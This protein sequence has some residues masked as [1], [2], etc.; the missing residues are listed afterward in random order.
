MLKQISDERAE[1][2]VAQTV[3]TLS[4]EGLICTEEN[5]SAMRRVARGETTAD[6]EI[7]KIIK[8]FNMRRK[9]KNV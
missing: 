2:I 7:D 1:E 4:F 8:N 3:A 5:I 6:A 9:N